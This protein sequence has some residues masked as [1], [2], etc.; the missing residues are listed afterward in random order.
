MIPEA[1]GMAASIG[2]NHGRKRNA[3]LYLFK[4]ADLNRTEA[5]PFR[6]VEFT[7]PDDA[8][9]DVEAMTALPDGRLL[10][11]T[12]ELTLMNTAEPRL[13][14]LDKAQWLEGAGTVQA[15]RIGTLPI[16]QWLPDKGFLG[17]AVTDAAYNPK[18]DVIGIL[19]YAALV[20]TPLEKLK[21]FTVPRAWEAGRDF[22]VVPIKP[23]KQQETMTYDLKGERVIW[24]SEFFPPETPIYSLSCERIEF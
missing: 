10:F 3:V 19:T 23:L 15:K 18:R 5:K 1:S 16:K 11:L 21:E 17:S 22:A 8:H 9:Y 14:T 4:E 20:E 24:S 2:N 12:K 13:F 6:K 7:Y